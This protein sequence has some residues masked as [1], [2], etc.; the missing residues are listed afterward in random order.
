MCVV[1]KMIP[2]PWLLNETL[3]DDSSRHSHRGPG[4]LPCFKWRMC[5]EAWL[6]PR[7]PNK[8]LDVLGS[9]QAWW[10]GKL[11]KE[12]SLS[13]TG[14]GQSFAGRGNGRRWRNTQ[15]AD[16]RTVVRM[17]EQRTR[18]GYK[19]WV[20]RIRGSSR[21]VRPKPV[22]DTCSGNCLLLWWNTDQNYLG[23][24]GVCLAYTSGSISRSQ[25]RNLDTGAEA[26]RGH[27]GVLFTDLFPMTCSVCFLIPSKTTCPVMALPTMGCSLPHQPL[28]NS[29]YHKWEP[30]RK[31]AHWLALHGLLPWRTQDAFLFQ[32]RP[33]CPG[34][35]GPAYSSLSP[36]TS[37]IN[38]E[39]AL[40][41]MSHRLIWWKQ[42]FNWGVPSSQVT[43]DGVKL[44]V[45]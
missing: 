33:S 40:T 26:D 4:P 22:L 17:A 20:A 41:D 32:H 14:W 13:I 19:A 45:T 29:L 34:R 7:A 42:C 30:S 3:S 44:T 1:F 31:V 12:Q 15:S 25:S 28:I 38:P 24:E 8:H 39:N 11:T 9:R 5:W 43:L 23:E 27:G 37:I 35:D 18:R 10:K 36:P 21:T 2:P 6:S 16:N